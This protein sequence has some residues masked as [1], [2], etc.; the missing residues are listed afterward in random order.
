[1]SAV[2]RRR[3]SKRYI[4]NEHE[5]IVHVYRWDLPQGK[6]RSLCGW[7]V[8]RTWHPTNGPI[9]LTALPDCERC[10]ECLERIEREPAERY[11]LMPPENW[12]RWALGD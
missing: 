10:Q 6:E 3:L 8:P 11:A 2:W 12:H 5:S 9:P 7:R 4:P 1:M